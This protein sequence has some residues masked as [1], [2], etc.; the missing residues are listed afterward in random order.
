VSLS[1]RLFDL[2]SY[3]GTASEAAEKLGFVSGHEFTR[4][5]KSFVFVIPS[6]LQPARNLLFGFFAASSAV[7][8]RHLEYSALAAAIASRHDGLP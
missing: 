7:P 2:G 4:A 3:Q 8:E 5:A 1:L 6:G